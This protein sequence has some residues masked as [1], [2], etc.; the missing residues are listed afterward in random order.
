ML[1][2][3]RVS[4]TSFRLCIAMRM[5]HVLRGERVSFTSFRYVYA[6]RAAE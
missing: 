3:E 6:M 2:G 5:R 4:F 1:R